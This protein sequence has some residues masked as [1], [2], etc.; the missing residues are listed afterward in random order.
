MKQIQTYIRESF[1][2]LGKVTWPTKEETKGST[3]VVIVFSIIA[4]IFI[5]A[6]D[7]GLSEI[8][9]KKVLGIL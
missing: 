8:L 3:I 4:S 7:Y 2:E 1:A 9:I 5:W 6:A